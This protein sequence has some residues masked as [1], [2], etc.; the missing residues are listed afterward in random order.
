MTTCFVLMSLCF[1]GAAEPVDPPS[2]L[3]ARIDELIEAPFAERKIVAAPPSDDAEFLRR[4]SIDLIGQIPSEKEVREFLVDPSSSKRGELI[5]RLL[6]DPRHFEHFAHSWRALLLPEAESDLQVDY[7]RPGLEAWLRERREKNMPFNA[8]VRD[9]LSVPISDSRTAPEMVI[10][11]LRRPN[12]LGYFAAKDAKPENLAASATRLFLGVRLECAQCHDH[13]F[14]HW[15]QKQFWNQAAF[16]AGL[17]RQGKGVF[18]PIIESRGLREIPV[19]Q[20]S[21][22]APPLF[23][24]GKPPELAVDKSPRTAFAEWLTSVENTQF[25]K[26]TVNRVWGQLLGLGLVDP[27]DDFHAGNL[28]SHPELLDE[29]T[30]R[31]I[32]SDFDLSMLIAA[33]CRTRAYQRTSRLTDPSQE[34]NRTFAKMAVKQMAAE[35]F[36]DSLLAAVGTPRDADALRNG[37][38]R[39]PLQQQLL[40]LF[41]SGDKLSDPQSS[42]LQALA[43]MN[44]RMVSDAAVE[45]K[46]PTLQSLFERSSEPA[47]AKIDALYLATLSRFPTESERAKLVDYLAVNESKE[48]S[49]RLGDVLWVLLN[50]VEFGCNH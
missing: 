16:F 41:S 28:P 26:A 42:I 3:A 38:N 32:E 11:D 13:P 43:L 50:S 8:I 14:G 40:D 27:V 22:S 17:E 34:E 49:R 36:V 29:L 44:G 15:T 9:L 4:I 39:D 24:D 12:P 30:T 21:T 2:R 47:S 5:D 1:A 48:L 6:K 20:T 18:S 37:R 19:M 45:Q 33:I 7:F 10:R 23:L 31:F 25:A 35:Q 46:S